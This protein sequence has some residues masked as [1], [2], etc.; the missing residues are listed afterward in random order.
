MED[1][2]LIGGGYTVRCDG[3][4]SNPMTNITIIN[5]RI[6]RGAYGYTAFDGICAP[7]FTGNVDDVTGAPLN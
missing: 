6:A 4:G 7:T 3:R 2:R 1:N 5:N